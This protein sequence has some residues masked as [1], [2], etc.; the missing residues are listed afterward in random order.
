VRVE[1]VKKDIVVPI[2]GPGKDDQE[3]AY[4]EADQDV[5][6]D[7]EFGWHLSM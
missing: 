7:G 5:N 1:G 4:F 6:D 3:Y 2:S